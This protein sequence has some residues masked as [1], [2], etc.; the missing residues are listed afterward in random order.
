MNGAWRRRVRHGVVHWVELVG[1]GVMREVVWWWWC[2][3]VDN[4]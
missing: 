1:V 3:I 4:H 2:H